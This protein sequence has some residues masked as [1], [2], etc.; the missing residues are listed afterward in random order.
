MYEQGYGIGGGDDNEDDSPIV[1][2]ES[3]ERLREAGLIAFEDGLLAELKALESEPEWM[4]RLRE[5]GLVSFSD[6]VLAELKASESAP[7][8]SGE[9]DHGSE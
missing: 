2:S 3:M 8:P 6:K 9:Q 7:D 5:L 4:Q 1:V